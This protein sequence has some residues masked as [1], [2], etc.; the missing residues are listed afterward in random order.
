MLQGLWIDS[1]RTR[2]RTRRATDASAGSQSVAD[3]KQF[4]SPGVYVPSCPGTSIPINTRCDVHAMYM[5]R[6]VWFLVTEMFKLPKVLQRLFI[7]LSPR[8][9][10]SERVANVPHAVPH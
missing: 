10:L 6:R 8:H 3:A 5:Q 2:R 9:C 4:P 1:E 7:Y